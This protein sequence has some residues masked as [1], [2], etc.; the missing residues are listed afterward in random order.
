MLRILLFF[1]LVL[2]LCFGFA[3]VA[4]R[5]GDVDLTWQGTQY[6]ASLMTVLAALVA[7]VAAVM[8]VWAIIRTILNTPAIM[9]R[10]SR[11]RKKD[12][13][14]DALTKGLI[15]AGSGDASTARKFTKD[16]VK[17]L[18]EAPLVGVLDAQTS[19]LEGKRDKARDRF[20]QM[21]E[22]DDTKLI[23][24]R[25]LFL[26]AEKQGA[27]DAARHYVE[28]AASL[29]PSVPWAGNA[30]LRYRATDGD[31]AGALNALDANRAAGLIEKDAAKRQRAVL[32]TAHAMVEEQSNPIQAVKLAK[33]AH[34]LAPD[35][36][37]AAIVGAAALMRGNE[38]RKASKMIEAVWK[39]EPHPELA[40]AYVHL[41]LGDSALDR[42]KRA[43]NL[44]NMKANHPEGKMAIAEASIEAQDWDK[45]R[46]AMKSVIT[47]APT[48]RACLIMADIEEG[49][50]G[51]KGRMRDWLSR[52]VRAPKDAAWTADGHVSEAWL[53]LSPVTG[54]I[55]AFEWK[56]PVE[57]LG[58]G[59]AA[60]DSEDLATLMLPMEPAEEQVVEEDNTV[61]TTGAAVVGAAAATTTT[62]NE[63][64]EED[65]ETGEEVD[66]ASN[67]KVEAV[68]EAIEPVSDLV[69]DAGDIDEVASDAIPNTVEV[70]ED[71]I[72][73][74]MVD[75][76]EEDLS[77]QSD[78]QVKFPLDRRPD[79]PGTDE[80]TDGDD[81][82]RKKRFGFF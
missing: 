25:G 10:W 82:P 81:Q 62:L 22:S 66:E 36:V 46:D 28:E 2:V 23:G 75:A 74:E 61:S 54:K 52:A 1:L 57:Q 21:L 39:H 67:E 64:V 47:N 34:K 29:A 65:E 27:K 70:V 69:Q 15:A 31:W 48:Q 18:G 3:W 68:D 17:L 7:I 60:L 73:D 78:N 16:S 13:G 53:P 51:D 37:P 33:E 58:D 40:N 24:L 80:A 63:L 19:L 20:E 77:T 6:S 45:A 5:P 41:R 11:Q 8:I 32:L 30:K 35:L 12:R 72:D 59:P 43:E 14:Y 4:D 76:V 55:D 9:S 56:V 26:E 42:L 38:L 49:E 44:A 79:D 50:H 71:T